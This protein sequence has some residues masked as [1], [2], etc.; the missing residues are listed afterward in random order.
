MSRWR[1]AALL[2]LPV[3]HIVTA[4]GL[5]FHTPSALTVAFEARGVRVFSSVQRRGDVTA[6]RAPVAVLPYAPH[7]RLTTTIVVPVIYKRMNPDSVPAWANAGIGDIA[8]SLKWAFLARDRFGGTTRLAVVGT[9]TL[10]TGSTDAL[11]PDGGTAPRPA[12]LGLGAA[13]GGAALVG[14]V[15]RGAWGL[16]ASAGHARHARADGFLR[17]PVTRYDVGVGLRIPSHVESI[18][19]Q[20]LQLYIEWNGAFSGRDKLADTVLPETGGHVAYLSPGA[21]WVVLPQLLLEASVQF[22][23]VQSLNGLQPE[24][25]VRPSA[26]MR[27]LFF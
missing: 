19:T 4:Q 17:G 12:Q 7:Q 13:S 10:P 18:R 9:A 20:T 26:G 6:V 21:Q 24:F 8:V 22:P 23:V 1:V 14:T 16:S 25:G 27:F 15:L 3:P 2:A 11:L 5:P